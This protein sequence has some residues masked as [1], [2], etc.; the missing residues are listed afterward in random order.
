MD[1]IT[2]VITTHNRDKELKR[3][4]ES[5]LNQSYKYIELLVIDDNST[6]STLDVVNQHKNYLQYIESNQRG[7][8][9]SRNIGLKM[10]KGEFIVF[11]D[12]DD[13][14]LRDSIQ[15][16]FSLFNKLDDSIKSKTAYIYSGC[17]LDLVKENRVT[18]NMP[19]IEGST[20][21]AIQKGKIATI[22]S[23]F[24]LNKELLFKH[25]IKFDETFTSFVDHDFFMS[26]A[27][28]K[29]HIYFVN[30]PLTKTFIYPNK[31]SMVNDVDKRI[32]NIGR[33]FDKWTP[34]F[35][36]N[37]QYNDYKIFKT[38]Y[39]A[40]EYSNLISNSILSLD[41]LS[42]KNLIKDLSS[43][44]DQTKNL[45][46]KVFKLTAFKMIRYFIPVFIIKLFK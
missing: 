5:V 43:F 9:F 4:I 39:I 19:L 2:V 13:E 21:L 11:L 29:L 36:K 22:P 45:R 42:L 18:Y 12:D 3:A 34:F 27:D 40:N 25:N 31:K 1:L 6:K 44:T 24:F 20:F 8:T 37:L 16:R 15:K 46:F 14:L 30:E 17:S 28:K 7:L 10:A 26:I 41:F 33:F 35:I 23:T 38:N 32:I